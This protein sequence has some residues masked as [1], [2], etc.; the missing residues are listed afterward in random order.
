MRRGSCEAETERDALRLHLARV[1][2]TANHIIQ[3][4]SRR[5]E[6]LVAAFDA[7]VKEVKPW[8]KR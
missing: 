4:W 1:V 7:A 8:A 6:E 2:E 5:N 3:A